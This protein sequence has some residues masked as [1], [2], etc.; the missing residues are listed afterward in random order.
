MIVEGGTAL[1]CLR[2]LSISTSATELRVQALAI[3]I[4]PWA[5]R[6]DIERL[7]ADP[8]EPLPHVDC[9]EL[10]AVV[11]AN[12]LRRSVRDEEIGQTLKHV[13]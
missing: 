5:V 12:L 4:L 3:A 2:Q 9:D 13:I 1:Q 11:G 8:A 7:D 6:F 10:W